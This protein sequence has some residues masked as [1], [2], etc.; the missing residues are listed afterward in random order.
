MSTSND[1]LR[2]AIRERLAKSPRFKPIPVAAHDDSHTVKMDRYIA[3]N[4]QGIGHEHNLQTMQ[5]LWTRADAVDLKA[6]SGITN[7]SYAPHRPDGKP[8]RHSNLA[9]IPGFADAPL[10]RFTPKTSDE[11]QRIIDAVLGGVSPR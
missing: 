5:H 7:E 4:G 1:A 2:L 11:A 9:Q 6:L 8:G 10:I 3:E